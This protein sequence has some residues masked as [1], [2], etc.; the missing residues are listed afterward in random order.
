M[1]APHSCTRPKAPIPQGLLLLALTLGGVLRVG[2]QPAAEVVLSEFMASN[3]RTLASDRRTHDDWIEIRNTSGAVVDLRGWALTDNPKRPLL[4]LFPSTNLPPGGHLLVWAT[5]HD[6]RVPGAPL[7]TS[8]KLGGGGEYLALVRPDGRVATE[9]SPGYPRQW[10][11]ISY[12]FLPGSTQ[13]VYFA[14]PTPGAANEGST[15]LPGPAILSVV[16]TPPVPQPAQ[17]L[18]IA[19][20][21]EPVAGP[22]TNV[23]LFW[24]QGFHRETNLVLTSQAPG[25]W[26]GSLPPL[27]CVAGEILRWRVVALDPLG[28]RSQYPPPGTVSASSRY[29]GVLVAPPVVT[30]A[31]PVFRLFLPASQMGGAESEQGARGCFHFDGEFYDNVFVKVRGN[32]TAG[33][34]KKSHRLEFPHDHPLRH[35]GPGGRV[36]H[37]SLMAEFGDPTYLR[38]HLSFWMQDASGSAAPFHYPV[39][40][41]LN[42]AFWQLA[43]HSE[44]LGEELL[45]RHGLDPDGALYKA[46]GTLTPDFSSTGGF[47]KKT[48]RQ[49]GPEDYIA[50]AEALSPARGVE[51][52][53]KT[54]YTGM[55]LP[56]VINYLA[57][58]RL[59]QEDDDIWA[60]MSLF[61]D[62]EGT[63]EWRP[64]AFDMNVSWGFSF[65]SGEVLA[66]A[67]RFR[68]HPFFGASGIG[69]S[70]GVNQLYDSVVAVPETRAMLL[71]R[72]RTILDRFWQPPGTP[73]AD[74]VIEQHIVAQTN[75]FSKEALLDRQRWG[76]GWMLPQDI[77][78]EGM[79]AAGVGDLIRR[80]IEPRRR[81]LYI[82]HCIT[83]SARPVGITDRSNAGIPESQPARVRVDLGPPVLDPADPARDLVT[84]TNGNPFAVDISGWRLGG[85]VKHTFSQGTVLPPGR[86]LLVTSDLA[87]FRRHPPARDDGLPPFV[88]GD[89]R[90]RLRDRGRLTLKD[91]LDRPVSSMPGE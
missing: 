5:G 64:V 39:R 85:R 90:G 70:Q 88:Q 10:A 56:A 26:S 57:V 84:L 78:P 1:D 25:L 79:L 31:L 73:F 9:F 28:H 4:W 80:F 55:N 12:G 69:A 71:R 81:H 33:F 58:A 17:P 77:P 27:A 68:S 46:V 86:S 42:G 59:T 74:R 44:V 40:V 38:Q 60:N 83:N 37:T 67:D 23:T 53:R 48:R 32:T 3:T 63:G 72:M 89:Y 20:R 45:A 36:R 19:V 43:M 22:A 21:V 62:N 2:A 35:P 16:H 87:A 91:D 61:H 15:N 24:R 41:E 76:G 66:Q 14:A 54:L 82:T 47:E 52:R 65:A 18:R 6:R 8:F 49:E 29:L 30:S 13:A 11:D 7:H 50:L 75:L 34:P 51:G